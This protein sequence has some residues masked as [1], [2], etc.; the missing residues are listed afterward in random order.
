MTHD[1]DSTISIFDFQKKFK[2]RFFKI[3]AKSF[4]LNYV[5]IWA[6]RKCSYQIGCNVYIGTELHITDNLEKKHNLFIEDRV[7]I[8]QRVLIVLDSHPNNS[9][10]TNIIPGINGTVRIEKD[11]WIGAGVIIL[12]NITVGELSIVGAGSVLTH[13]VPP[14]TI[15][16]GNPARIIRRIECL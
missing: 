8:A 6:L 10:L 1:R 9:H 5:R 7:S 13:D 16:A 11:A 12:P 14:K 2:K 15:V 4:P 3:I